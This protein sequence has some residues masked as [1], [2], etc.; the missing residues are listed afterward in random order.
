[1]IT[2]YQTAI[3]LLEARIVPRTYDAVIDGF[4]SALVH[5]CSPMELDLATPGQGIGPCLDLRG[6]ALRA[7]I[8]AEDAA[9]RGPFIAEAMRS[10][11]DALE[12]RAP[13]LGLSPAQVA[14]VSQ[15]IEDALANRGLD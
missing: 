7:R 10:W 5:T 14:E 12:Q 4:V 13:E 9:R 15:D 8:K 2:P 11:R 1:M 6:D 3:D